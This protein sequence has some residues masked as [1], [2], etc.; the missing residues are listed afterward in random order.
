MISSTRSRSGAKSASL[1]NAPTLAAATVRVSSRHAAT[2]SRRLAL[3]QL[4][5][6]LIQALFRAD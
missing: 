5:K 3:S 4:W 1:G 6:A 2:R